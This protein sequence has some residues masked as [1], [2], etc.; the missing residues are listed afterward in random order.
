M[1]IPSEQYRSF[2]FSHKLVYIGEGLNTPTP[3]AGAQQAQLRFNLVHLQAFD[4]RADHLGAAAELGGD[5]PEVQPDKRHL[6]AMREAFR[7]GRRRATIESADG[8]A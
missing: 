8:E 2:G 1:P 6:T 7:H 3:V 5:T 4:V